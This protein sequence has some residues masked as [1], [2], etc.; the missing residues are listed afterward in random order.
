MVQAQLVLARQKHLDDM[1]KE[2]G[3]TCGCGWLCAHEQGAFQFPEAEESC[4]ICPPRRLMVMHVSQAQIAQAEMAHLQV[5]LK[6]A[7]Q[8]H[9][10]DM[11][12]FVHKVANNKAASTRID[13]P[14]YKDS[15]AQHAVMY[16]DVST[17]T[18]A[19]ISADQSTQHETTTVASAGTQY[20]AA[21]L[22]DSSTQK[23]VTQH[24][25]CIGT[26]LKSTRDSST[27]NDMHT[28]FQ[29]GI[30]LKSPPPVGTRDIDVQVRTATLGNMILRGQ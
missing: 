14:S 8:M 11:G 19:Q 2:V 26:P 25:M 27:Q 10:D 28:D 29:K 23:G 21:K 13:I 9:S 24:D 20:Q 16:S 1:A 15:S 5:E 4:G 12:R 3:A 22:T 30:V 6:Q 17:G 7:R 18:L